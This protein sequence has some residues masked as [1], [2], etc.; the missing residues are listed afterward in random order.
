MN[1]GSNAPLP[2]YVDEWGTKHVIFAEQ[3]GPASYAT[4]GFVLNAS[5]FGLGGFDWVDAGMVSYSGTYYGRIVPQPA[6][7]PPSGQNPSM[8]QVKLQ[9]IV[10]STNLE[11]S[12]LTNLSGE[13]LRLFIVA[14][15]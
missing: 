12:S 15:V 10:A 1:A 11:V 3:A 4:G 2:G 14:P 9:W 8:K 13:I 6:S 5:D 7:A